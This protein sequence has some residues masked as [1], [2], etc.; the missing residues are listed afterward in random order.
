MEVFVTLAQIGPGFGEVI[1][2]GVGAILLYAVLGVLLMLLGF[3]AVDITT[4]GKLSRLV[5][6][7]MPN[8]VVVA[9]A[10]MVSMAFIVVVA[11]YGSTGGLLE[12]LLAS[13]V[14]GLVGI[15]AQVGGVRLLEWVTGIDIGEVLAAESIRPQAFVVSAAHVALGLVVA[16]AIL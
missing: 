9:A 13:L 10:G 14:F 5:R 16:V 11:I 1:G 4:P 8:A 7:G 3:Y 2:R 12:G 6:D 15:V